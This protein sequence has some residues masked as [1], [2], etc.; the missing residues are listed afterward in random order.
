MDEKKAYKYKTKLEKGRLELLE[1]L[2]KKEGPEDFGND[3]DHGD[4]EANE[5]ESLSARV[6][7][8]RGLKD[9]LNEIDMALNKIGMNKYGLCEK[10]GK[11]IEESVL[12]VAPEAKFCKSCNLKLKNKE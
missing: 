12:N 1:E 7:I 9:R 2:K 4:E 3:I 11:E 8:S 5:A 10:C 6:V